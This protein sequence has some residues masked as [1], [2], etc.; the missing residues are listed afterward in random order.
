MRHILRILLY[1]IKAAKEK[2][3]N[4]AYAYAFVKI[5]SLENLLYKVLVKT[6]R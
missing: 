6:A 1:Y 2:N 5:C 4:K 3:V